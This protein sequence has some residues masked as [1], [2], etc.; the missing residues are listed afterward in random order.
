[1]HST[2]SSA[3]QANLVASCNTGAIKHKTVL[4]YDYN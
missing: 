1:M 4:T 3:H 2:K